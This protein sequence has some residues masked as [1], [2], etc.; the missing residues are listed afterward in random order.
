MDRREK[1][2]LTTLDDY[3]SEASIAQI[4][5]L[6]MD[7]EGHEL[8]VLNGSVRM[9]SERR[10]RWVSFEFGGCNI[11]SR[12]FLQDFYYFFKAHGMEEFFRILP[13]GECQKIN[14]YRESLEQ[15]VTTNFLVKMRALFLSADSPNLPKQSGH[16]SHRKLTVH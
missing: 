16:V 14:S 4:E 7:V 5:L 13:S 11:D 8:D 1:I 15:F 9:F 12:T 3:C 10:V 6:K 2:R